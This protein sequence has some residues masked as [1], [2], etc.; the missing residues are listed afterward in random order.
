MK[1]LPD[2]IDEPLLVLSIGINPSLHS[3]RAGYPFAFSRNRFWPALN[4]SRLI[5]EELLPTV[6]AMQVLSRRY[7]IGFTDVVKKPT[8]GLK[9]LRAG[10]FAHWAPLLLKKIERFAPSI[11]WFHGKVAAR[12]FFKRS[13]EMTPDLKWGTQA[14]RVCGSR[15]FISPNPSPANAAYSLCTIVASYD[16][17]AKLRDRALERNG[18]H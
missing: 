2:F 18:D 16:E 12:E 8:R 11:L 9:D 17:L 5:T 15:C 3:V 1:T 7:G 13:L 14:F 4:A 6:S 10:D